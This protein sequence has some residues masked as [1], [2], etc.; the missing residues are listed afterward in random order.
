MKNGLR[1]L[2]SIGHLLLLVLNLLV[3][4]VSLLI[5]PVG[6]TLAILITILGLY[7]MTRKILSVSSWWIKESR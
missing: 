3:L 2:V 5:L 1:N 4:L 6:F 7:G